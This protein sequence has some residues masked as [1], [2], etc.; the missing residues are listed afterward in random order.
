MSILRAGEVRPPSCARAPP[1]DTRARRRWRP[2]CA[3]SAAACASARSS[4]SGYARAPCVCAHARDRALLQDEETAQPKL[5]YAK[6]PQDIASRYVLLL[7]P[8]L[9]TG[10]SAIKAVEVIKEHGVPEERIIFIN[11]VRAHELL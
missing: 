11:L 7:D 1:A 4:S 10:G 6:L 9:A 2:A 5:F 3:R 8:M